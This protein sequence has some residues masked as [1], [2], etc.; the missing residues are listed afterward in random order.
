MQ[1]LLLDGK[2]NN[3]LRLLQDSASARGR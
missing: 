3:V 1:D 2:H